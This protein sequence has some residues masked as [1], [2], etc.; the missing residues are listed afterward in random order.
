MTTGLYYSLYAHLSKA[1]VEIGQAVRAGSPLGIMG[2]TGRG[3]NRTRAHL[4]F[5]V[6]LLLDSQFNTWHGTIDG[7]GNPHG[8][9]NGLNMAGIPVGDYFLAQRAQ[10]GLS[11]SEFVKRQ[12]PHYKVAVPKEGTRLEIA[13]RYRWLMEDRFAPGTAWE[14]TFDASGLPLAVRSMTPSVQLT[15]PLVTWVKESPHSHGF[16]TRK[17]LTTSGKELTR[18]GLRFINLITGRF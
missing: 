4:H 17:R 1:T 15:Q 14:I 7:T 5:E 10:P 2:Y 13:R 11:I 3:L 18:S 12:E 9:Y 6:N 8:V 16:Q